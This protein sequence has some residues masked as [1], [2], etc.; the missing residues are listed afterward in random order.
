MSFHSILKKSFFFSFPFLFLL[1]PLLDLLRNL[2]ITTF[3]DPN[4]Y[5]ELGLIASGSEE[6]WKENLKHLS[7]DFIKFKIKWG[8]KCTWK[9]YKRAKYSYFE[10]YNLKPQETNQWSP[11]VASYW[12][13]SLFEE[14]HKFI[15]AFMIFKRTV[16]KQPNNVILSLCPPVP[17]FRGLFLTA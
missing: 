16:T 14:N 8:K 7:S 9:Q 15:M 13:A 11:K 3:P 6:L 5:I 4:F 10:I 1:F 2:H 17:C 12:V